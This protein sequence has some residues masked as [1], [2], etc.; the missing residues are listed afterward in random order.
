M[1]IRNITV[2]GSAN[3]AWVT[4]GTELSRHAN[5]LDVQTDTTELFASYELADN[6]TLQAGLQYDSADIYNLFVQNSKGNYDFNNLAQFLA[7]A[8]NNNGS[9]NYRTYVYNQIVDGVEPAAL[10]NEQNAGL[11]INDAWRVSPNLKVDV[12][13]RIDM[14]VLPDTVAFNQTFLTTFGER[15]DATYDGKKILQPRV[16]FNWQPDFGGKKTTIRGGF[17]LFYGRAPRVWIS[18][19]YS[20][21][22]LNFRTWSAGTNPSYTSGATAPK[23]SA[24]PAAQAINLGSGAPAMTV[25]FMDPNFELP[26][27]WKANLAIERELG[28]WGLKASAEIEQMWTKSDVFYSNINLKTTRTGPDGRELYFSTLAASS[29]GTSLVSNQFTN[30][31]IKLSNTDQGESR[32]VVLSLER[33]RKKD[34]WYWKAS[35]VN[36]YANE[37]LFGT[38]SVAAS[39][40]NN[41]SVFNSNAVEL[42]RAALE[43]RDKVLVNLTKDFELIKGY[44]TTASLLYEGRSGYPFSLVFNSD[45][46][47]DGTTNNDLIY[48]PSRSGDSKVR[49]AT[50]TDQANFFKIVDRFGLAEG[51]VSKA[52]SL[53]YPWVNQFD[54]G[55][56]QEIKL[57]GWRHRLTLGADILNV[58]NLL[59][60]KWGLIRGSNQF[61]V[62]RETAANVA[63]DAVN[64]Q[65]VYSN[66]S[67]ALAN[68]NDFNPS[69]GRGEPAATRWSVLFSA[70]YEF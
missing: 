3:T 21:T 65:Y 60:S 37:V 42:T 43:I 68:G 45:A 54:F 47:G 50:T 17:G 7:V 4:F 20:N 1:Q 41:R 46:N 2:P 23:V 31:T 24:D 48:V 39:N 66:V 49:F 44:R 33:P 56:K 69:L 58:G 18:N 15:N 52:N 8:A 63:F 27:K 53:R 22:G 6:H 14:A 16:G 12:G 51:E 10:F 13:A 64:N 40:W 35:Y 25:A 57:P 70:R 28:L 26:S 11:F 5:I 9:V 55:I 67:T 19:S 30:R 38:S 32:T 34:G 61:F 36:T 62:K 59:N 29:S